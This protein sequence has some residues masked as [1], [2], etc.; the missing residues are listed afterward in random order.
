M[1]YLRPE[2]E[3]RG[4]TVTELI[5]KLLEAKNLNAPVKYIDS[6]QRA[7]EVKNIYVDKKGVVLEGENI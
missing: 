2:M 4:R 5:N 6:D 7:V 1:L 3:G